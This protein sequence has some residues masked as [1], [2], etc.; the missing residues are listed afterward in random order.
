M[1]KCSVNGNGKVLVIQSASEESLAFYLG[2]NSDTSLKISQNN[3]Q[4]PIC[5]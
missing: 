2:L 4:L 5:H 3:L 1:S